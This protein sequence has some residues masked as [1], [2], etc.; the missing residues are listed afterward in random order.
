MLGVIKASGV[1]SLGI[2]PPLAPELVRK[3]VGAGSDGIFL[4]SVWDPLPDSL[5]EL[6]SI[7]WSENPV[8]KIS[9]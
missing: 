6:W 4:R 7:R 2:A 8:F 1:M 3:S 9:F 5:S